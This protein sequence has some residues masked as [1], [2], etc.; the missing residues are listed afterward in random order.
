[1]E[2]IYNEPYPDRY[3]EAHPEEDA[4]DFRALSELDWQAVAEIEGILHAV[5]ALSLGEV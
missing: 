1:M 2:N 3:F 4:T 5:A